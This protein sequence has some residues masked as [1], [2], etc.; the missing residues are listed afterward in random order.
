M[1]L[2]LSHIA[3]AW[4]DYTAQVTRGF[5]G[6]AQ[7]RITLAIDTR[8]LPVIA[9]DP[10]TG[11]S[12]YTNR[13]GAGTVDLPVF[14]LNPEFDGV[15]V[16][17]LHGTPG[18]AYGFNT[19]GPALASDSRRVIYFDLPGFA[20]MGGGKADAFEDLSATTYAFFV[21]RV[22]ET[23]SIERAH[24]VGWSNSGAVALRMAHDS[25]EAVASITMLG[26][27]G[28]QETEGSGSY[29]FE[30]A[31]YAVGW[32]SL[33]WAPN[34][35]PHFGV[36]L[37]PDS[38]RR[39]FLG[40]FWD[41]DQR[42]LAGIMRNLRT[43][44]LIL[45]GRDDFLVA[46][47]A[48][49]YH[50]E[51]IPSSALVMTDGDHFM[52]FLAAEDTARH[53]AEFVRR[54]DDPDASAVGGT[55]DLAPRVKPFGGIGE[56]GLDWL[57]FAPVLI[58][59]PLVTLVGWVLPGRAWV[60]VLVGA[61]ELDIGVAW[62]GLAV[63]KGVRTIRSGNGRNPTK[64]VGVL[65]EP[66]GQLGLG[67]V[68]VQ[69]VARPA[70]RFGPDWLHWLGWLLAVVLLSVLVRVLPMMVRHV[71]TTRGRRRLGASLARLTNH[72]WWPSWAYYAPLLPWFAWLSVRHR[73]VLV[74]TAC[75]PG[76]ANGGGLAGESKGAILDGLLASADE[77][78]LYGERLPDD[79]SSEERAAWLMQ[80]LA[81][82]PRLGGL[83]IV[84]KPDAGE[85]GRGIRICRSRAD[86]EAFVRDTPGPV[87]AQRLS[88][89]PNEVGVFYVRDGGLGR[90]FSVN[91][92]VFPVLTGDGRRTLEHLIWR[93][94]RLR[95]QAETFLERFAGRRG[96]VL[97][98]GEEL[99]LSWA[100]NH[101]Q[102]CEFRDAPELITPGLEEAVRSIASGFAGVDGGGLDYGRFDLRYDDDRALARGEFDVVEV[103]GVTS[104]STSIYDP[105][106]SAWFAWRTLARQWSIAYRIGKRNRAAGHRPVSLFEAWRMSRSH[107]R[108][109]RRLGH[110]S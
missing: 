16:V 90:V 8:G 67:F 74:F 78:V 48:A 2:A 105:R 62:L 5:M 70:I 37:G 80:R 95:C 76:I 39:A 55:V 7:G 93:H 56:A 94:K 100:G 21:L 40:N 65:A 11:L 3:L 57:H 69:V 110:A 43:P 14:D 91:R 18:S 9:F 13:E 81:D 1:L 92:K 51:L 66:V 85:Q 96:D 89:K 33:V 17:L 73:G 99:V 44:T 47:W 31:K 36:L 52:P 26:A 64:W 103:N 79:G 24:I 86:V 10:A 27:V 88:T 59:V 102:G 109:R 38:E 15:P 42:P 6:T 104:E 82:E 107:L 60:A 72:E 28:A 30:H 45:H 54:H 58:V 84:M 75:N 32:G 97:A 108:E 71:W 83:P 77:R 68:F 35:V 106:R 25:P 12:S 23:L 49:E 98:E 22:L 29:F 19:L 41:T 101:R 63:G 50:H 53:I 87:M 46:D 61:T 34:F 20:T 4:D